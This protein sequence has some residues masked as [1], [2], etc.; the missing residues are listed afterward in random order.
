MFRL[1][2]ADYWARNLQETTS[3]WIDEFNKAGGPAQLLLMGRGQVN[4][5]MRELSQLG[6]ATVQ[7]SQPPYNFSPLWKDPEELLDRLYST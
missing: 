6:I 3:A 1:A 5:A 2:V 7:L 4:H